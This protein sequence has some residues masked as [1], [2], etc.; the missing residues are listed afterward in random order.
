M[1]TYNHLFESLEKFNDYLD[2]IE[3]DRNRQVLMRIH[4]NVHTADMM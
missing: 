4:S 2:G 1:K 3:L